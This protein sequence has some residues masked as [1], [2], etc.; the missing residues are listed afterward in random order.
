M[1][2]G[3]ALERECRCLPLRALRPLRAEKRNREGDLH[4]ELLVDAL[5]AVRQRLGNLRAVLRC[6]IA[7]AFAESCTERSPAS[8]EY[9]IAFRVF[10]LWL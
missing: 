9:S 3:K 8:C 5:G 10:R 7:S 6:L 2:V 4:S 1:L